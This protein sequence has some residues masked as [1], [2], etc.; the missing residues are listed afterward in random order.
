MWIEN[1]FNI[2]FW[3]KKN[4]K[5]LEKCFFK[6]LNIDSIWNNAQIFNFCFINKIKNLD[7]DK[8]YKKYWLIIKTYNNKIKDFVLI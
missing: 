2:L 3:T 5:L 1:Q 4:T 8:V 6:A 7:I